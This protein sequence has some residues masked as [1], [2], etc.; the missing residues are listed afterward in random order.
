MRQ[1]LITICAFCSFLAV[2]SQSRPTPEQ[3][4]SIYYAYPAPTEAP[5]PAPE[6]YEPFYISHYGRHGSRWMTDDVRYVAMISLFDSLYHCS[7][8]IV[9]G[10]MLAD[11]VVTSHRWVNG[12]ITTLPFACTVIFRKCFATVRWSMR[13]LPLRSAVQ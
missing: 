9:C 6:G 5:A 13:V 8:C 12:S 4:G 10:M 3:L 11:A 1:I 2:F 7:H